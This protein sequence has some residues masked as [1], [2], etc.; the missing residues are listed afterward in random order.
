MQV[1]TPLACADYNRMVNN[2]QQPTPPSSNTKRAPLFSKLKIN[3]KRKSEIYIRA[4]L[5]ASCDNVQVPTHSVASNYTPVRSL[6]FVRAVN[7][8][9]YTAQRTHVCEASRCQD[10]SGSCTT[11]SL[12]A[13]A[14]SQPTCAFST[15]LCICFGKSF[16]ITKRE[17]YRSPE[18]RI[19]VALA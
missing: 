11:F 9:Y 15:T 10:F 13:R 14:R 6:S 3:E 7:T 5:T 17:A 1:L 2:S 4:I 8:F 12:P 16:K 18:C 19:R